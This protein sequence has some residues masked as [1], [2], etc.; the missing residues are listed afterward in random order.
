MI[1]LFCWL[2]NSDMKVVSKTSLDFLI[3]YENL[4]KK[5]LRLAK[6]RINM[7]FCLFDSWRFMEDLRVV[8]FHLLRSV[9]LLKLFFIY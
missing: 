2:F 9:L 8:L 7:V 5:A 4:S 1:T 6:E 3:V